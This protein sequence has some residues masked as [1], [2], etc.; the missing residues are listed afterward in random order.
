M[1]EEIFS[2]KAATY[3]HQVVATFYLLFRLPVPLFKNLTFAYN[4]FKIPSEL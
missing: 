3:Q 4:E 1:A 2:H